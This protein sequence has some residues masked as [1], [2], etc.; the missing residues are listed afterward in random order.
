MAR[1]FPWA[2]ACGGGIGALARYELE[3]HLGRAT[4]PAFP[5][6]T[7]GINLGGAFLLGLLMTLLLERWPPAR[8]A[9]SFV[10]IG[11]LGGFTTFSTVMVESDRLIGAGLAGRA[12]GY[13]AAS[14]LGGLIAVGAGAWAARALPRAGSRRDAA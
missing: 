9:R 4:P 8:Y 2:V 11:L 14:L 7:L 13:V 1:R 10:A 6:V 5:A 12:V 3:L